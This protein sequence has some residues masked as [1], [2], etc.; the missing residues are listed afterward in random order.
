LTGINGSAAE[1]LNYE[2]FGE[3]INSS[4]TRFTYTGREKDTITGLMYY[5]MRWYDQKQGRFLSE[6]PIGF[7]GS[8]NFY[9]YVEN[10]PINATDPKGLTL[11]ICNRKAGGFFKFFD[12]NH[13]FI[14]DDRCSDTDEK[15]GKCIQ[16]C[17]QD[18]SAAQFKDNF[19]LDTCRPIPGSEDPQKADQVMKCCA[20][21]SFPSIPLANDCHGFLDRCITRAGLKN[22]GSPGGRFGPICKP[23]EVFPDPP[24]GPIGRT[25]ISPYPPK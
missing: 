11:Y 14:Y 25:G 13:S 22:P 1:R 10:T 3:S 23:C 16:T 21:Q 20:N 2:S 24:R 17:G 9:T 5:R 7:R 12:G 8:M 15:A 19:N 18:S 6:D 4:L